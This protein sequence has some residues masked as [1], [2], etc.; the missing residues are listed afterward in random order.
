[1]TA[2]EP[3][4][5]SFPLEPVDQ[6]TAL[7]GAKDWSK[8]PLGAQETWSPDLRQ[9]VDLILSAGFPMALR[10]GPDFVL[11]FNDGDR[12]I[13]GDKHPWALGLPAREAWSEVWPRIE[14]VHLEIISGKR[15]A[16][17]AEDMLLRI[18]RLAGQ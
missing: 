14:P 1:M 9:V 6:L 3:R 13:L 11:I 5:L 17:F 4:A 12:P 10:C 18:R 15:G 16:L 8:T 2:N 7:V